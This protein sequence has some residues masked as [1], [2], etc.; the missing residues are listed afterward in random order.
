MPPL[1]S[2]VLT[3]RRS[4]VLG[5]IVLLGVVGL[6]IGSALA[7]GF[8]A[9]ASG[10]AG[11]TSSPAPFAGAAAPT[12]A[13]PFSPYCAPI[14]S[15]ICVSLA[16]QS[17]VRGDNIIPPSGNYTAS[18]S[19]AASA[20]ISLYVKS[21]Q[22][23]NWT[24]APHSGPDSPIALNV[25]ANLWNGDP[26]YS[27]YD[28]TT[29]HSSTA[30]WWTGPTQTT[31]VTYPWWYLVT[32]SARS[33]ANQPNFFAGMSV[34]WS[35]SITFNISG[36]YDHLT[37]HTF[38]YTYRAAWPFSP[39][40]AATQYA[41]AAAFGED[42]ATYLSPGAPNWNDV[43]TLAINA[44]PATRANN[45]TI[46]AAY[47]DLLETGPSGDTIVNTTLATP[48]GNGSG[49]G[50]TQLLFKVPAAY[51]QVSGATVA[52]SVHVS[53]GWG[54]WIW[55][56][57]ERYTIGGN[58][59]FFTGYFDDDLAVATTP[60]VA[61]TS[62]IV[63]SPVLNPGTTV[64]LTLTTRDPSTAIAA[65]KIVYTADLGPLGV[66]GTHSIALTRESSTTF[67]GK[68]P[69]F[70]V[71]TSVTFF[72]QA[73]DFTSTLE[74]SSTWTYS[75]STLS[76]LVPQ[77]P[78][79][80]TFFYV[81]VHDSGGGGAWVSGATVA[82]RSASGYTDSVGTTL[83]GLAYPNASG[84]LWQPALL[85]A[86]ASYTVNVSDPGFIPAGSAT[87][88]SVAVSL[89]AP[90]TMSAHAVLVSAADYSVIQNGNIL[91][92]WLNESAASTSL[93]PAS[94]S[95]SVWIPVVGLIA[96]ALILIPM[97]YWYRE[98]QARREAEVQRVTL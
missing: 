52:Y 45:A 11:A 47:V 31:N 29:W 19:P 27:I 21:A 33:S 79:N 66:S 38:Y 24:G 51:A 86:G 78:T 62:G 88:P 70:P 42:V 82:I 85:P 39:Y 36:H 30:S 2:R 22:P 23:L 92:F 61:S 93:T 75:V 53:D 1:S 71:G 63:L 89:V 69:G 18:V 7:G 34:A 56:P 10:A 60:N 67:V 68:I 43:A 97:I 94:L 57:T 54:N 6:M 84:K 3:S 17:E 32:I 98:I 91:I 81:G 40:P 28:G 16:N 8:F 20:N 76:S 35:I 14:T 83:F 77:I 49:I 80:S 41:G 64:T 4:S 90:H 65:A 26:Y 48:P 15:G 74:Q 95:P 72:V 46:G 9:G 12:A 73:W 5:S 25:N 37:S 44:T 96:G 55:G 58:G 59:S 13:G 87:P 50:A